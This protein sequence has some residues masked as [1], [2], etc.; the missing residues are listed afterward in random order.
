[1]D[2]KSIVI[3]LKLEEDEDQMVA[4]PKVRTSADIVGIA[5]RDAETLIRTSGAPNAVDRIHTAF[6]A[7]LGEL[8]QSE[9][10][11]VAEDA[12]VTTNDQHK[13]LPPVFSVRLESSG[14]NSGGQQHKRSPWNK[15]LTFISF[16]STISDVEPVM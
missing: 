10:I 6:Q 12:D 11:T 14:A 9:Q 8:C 15:R 1:M 7:Y 2:V 5:L 3:S 16:Y 4:A 13:A